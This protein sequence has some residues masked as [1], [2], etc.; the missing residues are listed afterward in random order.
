[1]AKAYRCV[2]WEGVKSADYVGILNVHFPFL[3]IFL[4]K[5]KNEYD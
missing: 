2:Q 1:M 3:K 4:I 5:K